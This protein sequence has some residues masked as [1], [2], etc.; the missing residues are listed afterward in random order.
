M[1]ADGS[2]HF[3]VDGRT[4]GSEIGVPLQRHVYYGFNELNQ[5]RVIALT[6]KVCLM[7][8]LVFLLLITALISC[9]EKEEGTIPPAAIPDEIFGFVYEWNVTPLNITTPDK[10]FFLIIMNGTFYK[11]EFNA[12]DQAQA[13]ATLRFAADTV[14]TDDSREFTNF[15][16]DAIAY[17]PI[18][19]NEI[20]IL[21]RDGRRVFGLF[22]VNNTIFSGTFGEQLISQWRTPG[23]P[24][25]PNQKAKDDIRN[26]IRRYSDKDGPGPNVTPVYLSVTVSQP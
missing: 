17:F 1:D 24:T 6:L 9:S 5:L 12:T 11:I 20:E 18:K 25:K 10:G 22:D 2:V 3:V 7:R 8:L 15:G 13:N 23:D 26:L 16:R 21:F 14:L 19:E 4:L